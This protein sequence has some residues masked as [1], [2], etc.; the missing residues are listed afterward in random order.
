L[1]SLEAN[2]SAEDVIRHP[3]FSSMDWCKLERRELEPPYMPRVVSINDDYFL[4]VKIVF[5]KC[6]TMFFFIYSSIILWI[7]IILTS[8]SQKRNRDWHLL[9]KPYFSRWISLNL[10]G[11]P[12]PIQMS[13]IHE[14]LSN[15]FFCINITTSYNFCIW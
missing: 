7:L 9:I 10:M 3:F 15:S 4:T 11:L 2:H 8:T 12:T 1:G 5:F 14:S 13:Q 6:N